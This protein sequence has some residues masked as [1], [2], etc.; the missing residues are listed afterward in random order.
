MAGAKTWIVVA[1]AGRMRVFAQAVP[2]GRLVEVEAHAMKAPP[3]PEER[4]RP[5]RVHDRLGPGRHA[6]ER[7]VSPHEAA[8]R[9]FLREAA[10]QLNQW[11]AQGD[12]DT[13]ILCAP[14]HAAG[15]IKAHLDDQAAKKLRSIVLKDLIHESVD[16]I[17][18]RLEADFASS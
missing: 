8:H 17:A 5:A 6:I 3:P 1:D 7:R 14:P 18:A 10:A 16:Q 2:G 11:A 4:S 12:Y 9:H 13:L 15:V